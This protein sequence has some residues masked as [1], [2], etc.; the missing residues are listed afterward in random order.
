MNVGDLSATVTQEVVVRLGDLVKAIGNAVNVQAVDHACLVHGVE[1]VVNGE[2]VTKYRGDGVIVSTPTGS[3]GYNLSA[4]GP[5][6]APETEAIIITPIC[7][8]SLN[9]RSIIVSSKDEVQVRIVRSKKTQ[10]EEAIATFDGRKAVKLQTDDVIHIHRAEADTR[11]VKL[12]KKSFFDVLR[13]K[14]GEGQK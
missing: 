6:I 14:L 3:T 8:H 5:V 2:E 12:S 7:P 1:I 13:T 10:E 9:A 4:G 11:L